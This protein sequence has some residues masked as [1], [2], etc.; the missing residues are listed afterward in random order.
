MAI[1]LHF[2]LVAQLFLPH[3]FICGL[4]SRRRHG[5]YGRVA[6]SSAAWGWF[7]P[8]VILSEAVRSTAESKNLLG[9]VCGSFT[10]H[11]PSDA[12]RY[13]HH[14]IRY[15]PASQFSANTAKSWK[16][17]ISSPSGGAG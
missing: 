6:A 8:P 15:C 10:R 14:A 3:K 12:I 7:W 1:I 11:R 9:F 17:T 4:F 13:T 2:Y 5:G 16:L